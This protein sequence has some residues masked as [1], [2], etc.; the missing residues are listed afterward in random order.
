MDSSRVTIPYFGVK[1]IK[2]FCYKSES[3]N[4]QNI[5]NAGLKIFSQDNKTSE[6]CSHRI[7]SE[8]R[9]FISRFLKD[10]RKV[11]ISSEEMKLL[12]ENEKSLNFREYLQD[13]SVA[14]L[15]KIL[16]DFGIGSIML[17][18]EIADGSIYEAFGYVGTHNVLLEISKE[19]RYHGLLVLKYIQ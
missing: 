10:Q 15:N 7:C 1:F 9:P 3:T 12:L 13:N 8:G 17:Q 5:V 18:V 16:N 14:S 6:T 19:E 11:K 4:K 2:L